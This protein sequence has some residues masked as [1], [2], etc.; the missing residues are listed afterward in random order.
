MGRKIVS[1]ILVLVM[2][3]A[4]VQLM[5]MNDPRTAAD[6]RTGDKSE[7]SH[8]D[9]EYLH[10]T[11]EY[12]SGII[13]NESIYSHGEIKKGRYFGSDGDKA[14]AIFLNTSFVKDCGFNVSE[15][16]EERLQYIDHQKNGY[17]EYV[18]ATS[19]ALTINHPSFPQNRTIPQEDCYPLVAVRSQHPLTPPFDYTMNT[20]FNNTRVWEFHDFIT[21]YPKWETGIQPYNITYTL[22]NS[23][24][25]ISGNIIYV[26]PGE[27]IPDHDLSTVFILNETQNITQQIANAT[28]SSGIILMNNASTTQ[29]TQADNYTVPIA[30]INTQNNSANQ[31]NLTLVRRLLQNNSTVIATNDIYSDKITFVHNLS[32]PLCGPNYDYIILMNATQGA[33]PILLKCIAFYLRNIPSL[34]DCKGIIIYDTRVP[35]SHMMYNQYIN[36]VRAVFPA[37]ALPGFSINDTIGIFLRDHSGDSNNTVTGHV[38]QYHYK[39]DSTH[40]YGVEAYNIEADLHI[41]HS[42][43]DS[44]VILSSRYDSMWNEC[45]G[46]SGAG[47]G[48]IMG[49]AKYMQA[50]NHSGIKPNYNVTFLM[51]TNEENGYYGA[52]FFSDSH[53]KN[54]YNIIRWIGT[55]QLGFFN[56]SLHNV[57][58]NQTDRTIVLKI[59]ELLDYHGKTGYDEIHDNCSDYYPV[60]YSPLHLRVGEMG[61]GAEDVVFFDRG[62]C[63]TILIHKDDNWP[64]HHHRGKNLTKGDVLSNDSFDW[65]DADMFYNIT[66]ATVQY[67]LYDPDCSLNNMGYQTFDSQGGNAKDSLQAIFTVKSIL[68]HDNVMVKALLKDNTNQTI[69]TKFVNYTTN[70]TGKENHVNF[71]LPISTQSGLYHIFLEL[72]NSTGIINKLAGISDKANETQTSPIFFLHNWTS[73]GSESQG[74]ASINTTDCISGTY[75]TITQN[76]YGTNVTAYL[77]GS[78]NTP[79]PTYRCIIYRQNDSKL[80]GTSNQQMPT[81]T[82]WCTFTFNP[83]QR[84]PLHNGVNYVIT[85]WGD[86]T[87]NINYTSTGLTMHGKT[88]FIAYG[89]NPPDPASFTF[90]C[91]R[92]YALFCS[93]VI[94]DVPPTITNIA[95]S[96]SPVGFGRT[97]NITADITDELSGVDHATVS[98][99]KPNGFI[100][101]GTMQHI[102]GNHY[103]L[104]FTDT[105][106]VGRYNYTITAFDVQG[107]QA[108]STTHSFNVTATAKLSVATTKDT[109]TN[110]QYINLTDPPNPPQ[111]YTLQSRGP[112]W[113]TYY[114]TTTGDNVLEVSL[115]QINYQPTPNDTWQPINTTLTT[116]PQDSLAYTKGYRT[117]NTQGPYAVYFKPTTQENWPVAFAYNRSTDPTTAV[118]RTKLSSVGY[119]DP[120][121]WST[122]TLQTI[123]NSQGQYTGDTVTYPGVFTGTDVTYAYQN[124]QLKEVITLSNTTKTVLLSHPPSQYGLSTASYL[125]FVTKIDSLSLNAYDGQDLITGNTSINFGVEYKDALSHVACALPIGTAYEQCNTSASAS[126]VYRIIH[127]NGDTYLLS[128]IPY[129]TLTAMTFPVVIDPTITVYSLTNDGYLYN[130]S[131]SYNTAWTATTGT[132][133]STATTLNIG[134]NKQSGTSTIYYVYR[135]MLL[136]NTTTLPKNANITSAKLA[137]YKQADSSTTDFTITVQN[138]QPTYPHDPLQAGDYGKS[139][140]SGNGGGLNT[141]S[142][143]TGYNNITLTNT[144]DS[145]LKRQGETKLC[146]RSSRDI[147]G[148]TPTTPEYVTIYSGNANQQYQPKLTIVYRNQ[149]KINNTGTTTINGYLLIQIQC[150]HNGHWVVDND[151]INDTSGSLWRTI[152]AGHQLG[153]DTI[154]NGRV[155]TNNLKYGNGSYRIFAAFRDPDGNLLVGSD[156][157]ALISTWPF[158]VSGL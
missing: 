78:P 140:Y 72:Y 99:H 45:P 3:L 113:N 36:N 118:V 6:E 80:I 77:T 11:I 142:F 119:I 50:L 81:T 75:Y 46:D 61:V 100:G 103:K 153:L 114:D 69:Q 151:T 124:T 130:S 129:V 115:E 91:S 155:K 157:V 126:L 43:N 32:S 141:T 138:G 149:S 135:G 27:T 23:F 84:P 58:K 73:I 7:D 40:P 137:L 128:G 96:P 154:F 19:Y 66:W 111:N 76:G 79:R 17:S 64:N 97:V 85:I 25:N 112:T 105:W 53:P 68:P 22:L 148:N 98:V 158:T 139:H 90:T 56:G 20:T 121:S 16:R 33:T 47:N 65:K 89:P 2:V 28:D 24:D 87:T 52:E 63:D 82:G 21:T 12:L 49:I 8:L 94:D 44:I 83:N 48:I 34:H 117:A 136:F 10:S 18:N 125:T 123:Q 102:T 110:N 9:F 39:E 116:L 131:T 127:L 104:S 144:T 15:V 74:T 59:T 57:Y 109:F 93:Y 107:N 86:N 55:D 60:K 14:A 120:S 134:Q 146:L 101:I 147:N 108:S 152:L 29:F 41:P 13:H 143:T 31:Q 51:T 5:T 30:R 88:Q 150:F 132:I 71:T 145:W 106:K 26:P 37:F 38:N 95:A 122:H 62:N 67:Y 92:A 156:Q 4:S 42:P 1:I 35:D 133:S 70:H 54:E